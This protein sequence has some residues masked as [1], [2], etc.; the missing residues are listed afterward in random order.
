MPSLQTFRV[1]FSDQ[2]TIYKPGDTIS[3]TVEVSLSEA[4]QMKE[5]KV[6]IT[7]KAHVGWHEYY[8]QNNHV[9]HY[10][11]QGLFKEKTIVYGEG[12]SS[13]DDAT[14][15]A[16]GSHSFPFSFRLPSPLPS[17]YEDK[18]GYVRYYAKA[19]IVRPWKYDHNTKSMFTL[20]DILDLNKEQDMMAPSSGDE[21]KYLCCLC[22]KSGPIK[23]KIETDRKGYVPGEWIVA[24]GSVKNKSKSK[25]QQTS[26]ELM[27][28]V[29]YRAKMKT[30]TETY[31]MQQVFGSHCSK[32]KT[33]SLENV[34]LQIPPLPPTENKHC[35]IIDINYAV[36]VH[37]HLRTCAIDLRGYAPIVIGTVPLQSLPMYSGTNDGVQKRTESPQPVAYP[38]LSDPDST[39]IQN[40]TTVSAETAYGLQVPPPPSYVAATEGSFTV[41]DDEYTRGDKTYTP[42]YT[43]YDWSQSAFTYK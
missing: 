19:K 5:L 21:E 8:G 1:I 38:S 32:G 34:K 28:I 35:K 15:L 39:V 18:I 10:N 3:G 30:K 12:G 14:T 27:K 20:L 22:C 36:M 23:G 6:K 17:S 13:A 24:T 9:Y 25:V 42:Q 2:K 4:M 41:V 11:K 16:Q 29:T 7:G 43:F 26:V 31:S 33:A 40:P 37:G